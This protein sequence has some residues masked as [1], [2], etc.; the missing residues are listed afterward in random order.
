MSTRVAHL[1]NSSGLTWIEV[2]LLSLACTTH[3]TPIIQSRDARSAGSIF[4]LTREF[5]SQV[6]AFIK[7]AIPSTH[8][9][10]FMTSQLPPNRLEHYGIVNRLAHTCLHLE[11]HESVQHA[12]N[13][14]MLNLHAN[15]KP[16]QEQAL[17]NGSLQIRAHKFRGHT[18]FRCLHQ[19][20]QLA[21]DIQA[22]H[23]QR[24]VAFAQHF[25]SEN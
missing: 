22:H 11:L 24:L 13:L 12:L 18:T 7:F 14:A 17:F 1:T 4:H 23:G 21:S 9:G 8:H 5:A 6:A 25:T 16:T 15:L 2:F 20:L 10:P 3:P 19:V